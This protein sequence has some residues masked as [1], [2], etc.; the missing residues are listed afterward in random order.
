MGEGPLRKDLAD[1]LH[2]IG[3]TVGRLCHLSVICIAYA[4]RIFKQPVISPV[5]PCKC[6]GLVQIGN[7][8][9]R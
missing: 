9:A 1:V 6:A 5:L 2:A 3:V 8:D 4:C 7:V